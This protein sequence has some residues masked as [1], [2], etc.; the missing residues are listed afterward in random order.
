MKA[1]VLPGSVHSSYDDSIAWIKELVE[2]I[3]MVYKD[4]PHV[5]FQGVCFGH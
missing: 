3:R 1:I 2:F 4:F 5:K